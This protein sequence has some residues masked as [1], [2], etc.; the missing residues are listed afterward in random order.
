MRKAGKKAATK[1]V[2][3]AAEENISLPMIRVSLDGTWQKRGHNS[4][5]GVISAAV[6]SNILDVEVLTTICKQ[7]TIWEKRKRSPKLCKM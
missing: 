3:E 7:C 2:F 1:S 5:N 4:H 6:N